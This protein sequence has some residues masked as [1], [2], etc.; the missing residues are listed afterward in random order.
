MKC[1]ANQLEFEPVGI[2]SRS[3][4]GLPKPPSQ[5]ATASPAEDEPFLLKLDQVSRL[6][7]ISTRQIQRL[8]CLG[9]FPEEV[10]IGGSVRWRRCDIQQWV[11]DGCPKL[12]NRR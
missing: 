11:A 12:D 2:P 4:L 9:Q 6:V 8:M 10:R 1:R 3:S 5:V 7:A